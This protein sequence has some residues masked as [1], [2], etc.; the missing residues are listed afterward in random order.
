M[1]RRLPPLPVSEPNFANLRQDGNLYIDKT[2]FLQRLIEEGR[3]YFLA[4]PRRFGKSL[5]LSTLEAMF[6]G[7]TDLFAGLSAEAWVEAQSKHPSPVVHLDLSLWDSTGTPA[8]LNAWLLDEVL[9]LADHYQFSIAA[10]K[11]SAQALSFFLRKLCE[12]KGQVVVLI[13]EY[14]APMLANLDDPQKVQCLRVVLREFYK[15]LKGSSSLIRFVFLTGISKFTKAGIFSALNNLEDISM[16]EDYST[17]TGYTDHELVTYFH[18]YI[19]HTMQKLNYTERDTFLE[20]VKKYY[21]GY[22]FDGKSK[23]YNPY[24][25]VNFFKTSAFKN[26]WYES[27][28]SSSVATYFQKYGINNPDTYRQCSISPNFLSSFEIEKTSPES[29]F[30]QTGYLTIAKIEENKIILDYPNTEIV[31]SMSQ[32]FMDYIY[33]VPKYTNLA[34]DIWKSINI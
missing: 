10:K 32:M 24:S 23:V 2:G 26:F 1:I 6:Q 11:T 33:K 19:I 15:V 34:E 16:S 25:I 17:L 14:D 20:K 27:G 28:S 29:F 18:E 7:R 12:A 31:N 21:D 8:D 9:A 5:T 22:C 30:Y 4:R 13:D 3:W